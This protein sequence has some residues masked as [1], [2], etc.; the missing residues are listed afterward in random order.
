MRK[1][2]SRKKIKLLKEN[3]TGDIL[4]KSDNDNF[5]RNEIVKEIT[6][7][8]KREKNRLKQQKYRNKKKLLEKD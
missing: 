6:K 4:A 2:K 1:Q 3:C 5:I 7:E 8:I